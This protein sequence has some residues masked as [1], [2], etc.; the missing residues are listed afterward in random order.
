MLAQD[1][2]GR[3]RVLHPGRA[4]GIGEWVDALGW[5]VLSQGSTGADGLVLE[6]VRPDVSL[7]AIEASTAVELATYRDAWRS[8]G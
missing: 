2:A 1:G 6:P 5:R 3:T 8:G 4:P 7:P